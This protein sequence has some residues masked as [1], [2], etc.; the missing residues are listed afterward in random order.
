M[1]LSMY[2]TSV[3]VFINF[4]NNL[5]SIIEYAEKEFAARNVEEDTILNS[6][7]FPDMYTFAQQI[8][9]VTYHAA[10]CPAALAGKTPPDLPYDL[11]SFKALTQRITATIEFLETIKESDME[12]SENAQIDYIVGG[13]PRAFQGEKLLLGHCLPNIFF[14][15]TT[16]YNILRHNGLV[17]IKANFMGYAK[18][19][20]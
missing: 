6:R 19:G 9:Q 10:F 2:Q 8:R 12:G 18:P 11:S 17:L 7:L 20:A 1:S 15:T 5:S 4:M 13:A 16:A 14:H 3:P